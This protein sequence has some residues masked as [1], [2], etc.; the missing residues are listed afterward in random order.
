VG[1]VWYVTPI[2]DRVAISSIKDGLFASLSTEIGD[3]QI[4]TNS[5][6]MLLRKTRR[7]EWSG[8]SSRS[9]IP[10]LILSERS[11]RMSSFINM[12]VFDKKGSL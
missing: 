3:E 12:I 2:I 8:S 9:L 7:I 5:H 1:G 4:A 10:A 11:R 6:D